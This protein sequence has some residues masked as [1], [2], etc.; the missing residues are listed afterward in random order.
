MYSIL[1]AL[2]MQ[3]AGPVGQAPT[4]DIVVPASA[5]TGMSQ[6]MR[7]LAREL[8][9]PKPKPGFESNKRTGPE[10]KNFLEFLRPRELFRIVVDRYLLEV[11]LT[12]STLKSGLQAMLTARMEGMFSQVVWS[13]FNPWSVTATLTFK[14]G[15][16]GKI[17]LDGSHG[18]YEDPG[19]EKRGLT[20]FFNPVWPLLYF[21]VAPE[22]RYGLATGNSFAGYSVMIF[23]PFGV[24]TTSSSMRAAE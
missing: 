5:A 6:N 11:G 8:T 2:V 18:C 9:Q 7:E 23:A 3:V 14:D 10:V 13:E 17:I 21:V 19:I 20:P 12:E 4:V 15:A 16:K 1:F 22:P 24:R